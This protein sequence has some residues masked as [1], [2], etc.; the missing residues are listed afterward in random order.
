[1][2]QKLNSTTCWSKMPTSKHASVPSDIS[3]DVA[4]TLVLYCAV[5]N[6]H[7]SI[8]SARFMPRFKPTSW[9]K[10]R[11]PSLILPSQHGNSCGCLSFVPLYSAFLLGTVDA[12]SHLLEYYYNLQSMFFSCLSHLFASKLWN[13]TMTIVWSVSCQGYDG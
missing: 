9:V 12:C 13:V 5:I 2:E 6:C 8:I 4:D 3:D 11:S 10:Q 7:I 1:M